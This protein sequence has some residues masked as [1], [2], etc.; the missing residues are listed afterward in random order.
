MPPLFWGG[1]E[2]EG[3]EWGWLTS[4]DVWEGVSPLSF[5]GIDCDLDGSVSSLHSSN[6]LVK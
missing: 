5:C 2:G 4:F 6:E 1:G 3:E